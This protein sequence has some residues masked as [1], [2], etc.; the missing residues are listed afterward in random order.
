MN[1][2]EVERRR[3]A[4]LQ[5]AAVILASDCVSNVEFGIGESVAIAK[6]L[7]R[8]IEKQEGTGR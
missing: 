1:V 7:L 5:A 3:Y 8:E 6:K 4:L 2:D